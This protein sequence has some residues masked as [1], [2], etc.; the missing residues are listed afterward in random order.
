MKI[1][2]VF[3]FKNWLKRELVGF[4]G[5][6][7]PHCFLFAHLPDGSCGLK[8][9]DYHTTPSPWVGTVNNPTNWVKLLHQMPAGFPEVIYPNPLDPARV[10]NL[11]KHESM[12]SDQAVEWAREVNELGCF[13]SEEIS[14]EHL[15]FEQVIF[16]LFKNKIIFSFSSTSISSQQ[17]FFPLSTSI[18]EQQHTLP[19]LTRSS[20]Q[21]RL[22]LSSPATHSARPTRFLW[23][24]QIVKLRIWLTWN[25]GQ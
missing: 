23:S 4:K 7:L 3:D 5:H 15:Y 22:A 12:M 25:V 9:K 14:L 10:K 17:F 16:F 18:R 2:V 8:M 20:Q 21:Q 24:R 13:P 19:R 6:T 11:L 1:P